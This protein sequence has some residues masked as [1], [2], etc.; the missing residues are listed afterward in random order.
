MD[1][2]FLCHQTDNFF[3]LFV[4]KS[5]I[6]RES[7]KSLIVL[8]PLRLVT[9]CQIRSRP[10]P[11]PWNVGKWWQLS[12]FWEMCLMELRVRV[13]TVPSTSFACIHI[14]H[15][16]ISTYHMYSCNAQKLQPACKSNMLYVLKF[17]FIT[18]FLQAA[19]LTSGIFFILFNEISLSWYCMTCNE[20]LKMKTLPC[21]LNLT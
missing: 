6:L 7:S 15:L 19:G 11:H 2:H 17:Y 8:I 20:A 18:I 3:H 13:M 1:L 9:H 14:F 21:T 16:H 5:V 4:C 12:L 10:D